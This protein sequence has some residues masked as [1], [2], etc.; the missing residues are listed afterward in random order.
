MSRIPFNDVVI[1]NPSAPAFHPAGAPNISPPRERRR[2]PRV[3]LELPVRVRWLGPFGLET[4]ITQT[5]NA[6]RGGLLVSSTGARQVGSLLWAT[7]PYDADVAFTESETPGKVVRSTAVSPAG[8]A[9]AVEIAIEFHH[10]DFSAD[11]GALS[12]NHSSSLAGRT[13]R[14]NHLRVALAFLIR[15]E[16]SGQVSRSP[17]RELE[18]PL[19]PEETMTVDVSP[20]GMLF[21][22]LRL[23]EVGE[24]LVIAAESGRKLSAGARRARVVRVAAEQTDSP[25][26]LVAVE[27]LS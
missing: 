15:V 20:S 25:L 8:N 10:L 7:F 11:V 14:R 5:R 13:E 27:F 23:Y 22:T 19:W 4:E 9:P 18:P 16:R 12:P 26:S 21:C 3:H 17:R 1:L 2:R 24:R 6:S